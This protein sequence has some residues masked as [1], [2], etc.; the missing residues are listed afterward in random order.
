[1]ARTKNPVWLTM[2]A[3][4]RAAQ[5]SMTLARLKGYEVTME[6][7]PLAFSWLKAK[8]KAHNQRKADEHNLPRADYR[9]Q[10][11]RQLHGV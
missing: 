7:H 8:V 11:L 4:E 2:T 6:R 9:E 10:R 3:D 1:M 5:E